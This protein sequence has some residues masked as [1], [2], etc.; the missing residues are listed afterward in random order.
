MP[1]SPIRLPASLRDKDTFGFFEDWESN[2]VSGDRWTPL[3]SDSSSASTLVIV[4]T[5]AVGG[6]LSITQ[7][8]TNNDEIYFGTTIKAFKIAANKPCYYEARG[9]YA[10]GNTN[11]NNVI[12]GWCS[13]YAADTLI[14]DGGGPVASATMALIYKVDGGT[15]WRCRSQIGAG[16]GQTDT[17]SVH[18]A[19][20][21]SYQTLGVEIL[22]YS[23]TNAKVIYTIDG[24]AMR[25]ANNKPIVHDLV[26]T[27]AVAMA[28]I[29]GCK[30]G[31][32]TAE[33][34]LNDYIA[35][36]QTR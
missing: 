32:A 26:Y 19:G 30:T 14:D 35:A 22:P 36:Y 8:A 18:T 2:Y 31:S 5:T 3:T 33:V 10:E 11:A 6:I 16:V 13:T 21:S 27:N 28:P 1:T 29:W 23:S 4:N 17:V 24:A 7:D 20:G 15:V 9:Q 34:L 25:D 12:A